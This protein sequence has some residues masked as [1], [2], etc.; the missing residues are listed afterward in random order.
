[1]LKV[2]DTVVW[3]HAWNTEPPRDAVVTDIENHW[4]DGL[5]SVPWSACGGRGIIVSLEN[6]HWAYGFQI[7]P[8]P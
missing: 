5:E 1:M 8:K 3:R 4:G 2:G 7:W 6:G